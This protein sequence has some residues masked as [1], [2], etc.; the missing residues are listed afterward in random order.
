ML[1]RSIKRLRSTPMAK[2]SRELMIELRQLTTQL[3]VP[4]RIS[5]LI[6]KNSMRCAQKP[7]RK[8]LMLKMLM[9][10]PRNTK[11]R[12]MKS[13]RKF[14]ISTMNTLVATVTMV[15]V[16]TMVVTTTT[17]VMETAMKNIRRRLT[18]TCSLLK[19]VLQNS[20][21]MKLKLMDT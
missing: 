5:W 20:K 15:M 17:L 10:K 11:N 1:K 8:S 13:F 7:I 19:M 3:R 16:T 2:F 14:R 9:R 12:L 18:S 6:S 4:T 21:A